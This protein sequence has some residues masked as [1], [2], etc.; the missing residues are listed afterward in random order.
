MSFLPP[1]S[2]YLLVE[3]HFTWDEGWVS[4]LS[5]GIV[6]SGCCIVTVVYKK[7]TNDTFIW[8]IGCKEAKI[9]P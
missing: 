5:I 6:V 7:N 1:G 3:F 2:A 4:L 8:F 9:Y